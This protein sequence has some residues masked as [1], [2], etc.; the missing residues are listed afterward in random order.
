MAS[1]A[2]C[3]LHCILPP[4]LS[5][6]CRGT[7]VLPCQGYPLAHT[8]TDAQTNHGHA[9]CPHR[10]LWGGPQRAKHGPQACHAGLPGAL[11]EAGL[12]FL[13]G[14]APAGACMRVCVYVCV[15]TCARARVILRM[16]ACAFL[17][18]LRNARTSVE[19][20]LQSAESIRRMM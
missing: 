13:Q 15:C 5:C 20:C 8:A 14:S 16:H 9:R 18:A 12:C 3:P 6:S 1:Y 4:P 2:L 11:I 10:S 19:N 7:T 17:R